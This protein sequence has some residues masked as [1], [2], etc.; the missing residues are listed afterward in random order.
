M[1]DF[2][3]SELFSTNIHKQHKVPGT[4]VFLSFGGIPFYLLILLLL[5]REAKLCAV[6]IR[7]VSERKLQRIQRKKHRKLQAQVFDLWGQCTNNQK[8]AT[9]LLKACS[10]LNGPTR[11][12]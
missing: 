2:F 6:Q 7:L 9:Q 12:D 4:I 10:Y 11:V 5:K 1:H 3:F 8:T